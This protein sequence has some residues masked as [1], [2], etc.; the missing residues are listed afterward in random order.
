ML[1]AYL[2]TDAERLAGEEEQ[3]DGDGEEGPPVLRPGTPQLLRTPRAPTITSRLSWL[4][5]RVVMGDALDGD[6]GLEGED[7]EDGEGAH[8]EDQEE[9]RLLDDVQ[10]RLLETHFTLQSATR[11]EREEISSILF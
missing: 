7:G 10:R 9:H 1:G 11:K 8:V 3:D 2:E 4:P 6:E 5:P